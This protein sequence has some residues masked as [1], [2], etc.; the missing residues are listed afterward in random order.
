MELEGLKVNFLGDSITFGAQVMPEDIFH[1]VLKREVGLAEARNYG[2]GG[3]RYAL[4]TTKDGWV[5]N[6][7]VDV[8]SFCERYH[9]MDDDADMVVVFGGTNDYGHGNADLGEFSDRTADTFYGAC[10]V[11][12]AGLK[13]KYPN[14]PIVVMTPSPRQNE[15]DKTACGGCAREYGTLSDYVDIICRVAEH[16]G[17]PVFD[18]HE[19]MGINPDEE[20]VREE[21][22]PDGLHP[23]AAGH[24]MIADKLKAFLERL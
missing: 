11:L 20:A 21:F 10:H 23:N 2:I 9:Q 4:Q 8:N 15:W 13:E 24:R 14:K 18:L 1:A 5:W 7:V 22:M 16:Y 3:T 12:F 19:A 6:D 17:L